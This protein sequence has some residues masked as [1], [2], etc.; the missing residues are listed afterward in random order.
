MTL[1]DLVASIDTGSPPR[2][3][4]VRDPPVRARSLPRPDQPTPAPRASASGAARAVSSAGRL[5]PPA[6]R[7]GP[8][9]GPI[10]TGAGSA[11]A[12]SLF[13]RG[14]GGLRLTLRVLDLAQLPRLI[15]DRPQRQPSGQRGHVDA[16]RRRRQRSLQRH[17]DVRPRAGGLAAIPT[18]RAA[19][20]SMPSVRS[21]LP[22]SDKPAS[23]PSTVTLLEPHL[24]G[25]DRDACPRRA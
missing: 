21:R 9:A 13:G 14:A 3:S 2:Q 16:A 25:A 18:A 4:V 7:C 10:S 12:N 6:A 11:G 24:P 20:R 5:R 15:F 23:L 19:R 22:A 8:G 1:S 17:E